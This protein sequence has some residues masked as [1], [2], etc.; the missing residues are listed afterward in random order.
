MSTSKA[1]ANAEIRCLAAARHGILTRDD[2]MGP[3]GLTESAVDRRLKN[4]DLIRLHRGIY[5][6]AAHPP[7][8]KGSVLAAQLAGGEGAFSSH[9][10]AGALYAL[11]GVPAGAVEVSVYTGRAIERVVTHRLRP[12]DRP[13]VR[14]L[15]ELRV[16]CMER[17]LLDLAGVLPK[18]AT[19][20]ALDDALRRRLTTLERMK[21]SLTEEGRAGRKGSTCLRR[22][23]AERDDDDE[24]VRTKFEAKMLWVIR[25]LP[26]PAVPNYRL[27]VEG[28]VRYLDFAFP[29]YALGIE[30]HSA[31]WH[32]AHRR[33]LRDIAR[34]RQLGR[35]G[36]FILYFA[37]DE[38]IA[39]PRAVLGEIRH[40][41]QDRGTLL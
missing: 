5:R 11:D 12:D 36:W 14:T 20:D 6:L 37:W 27:E 3:C 23:L 9:R 26:F 7:T 15:D 40:A 4:G 10:T 41:L 30:C 21:A 18:E 1:A 16:A 13:R 17:T 33:W 19:A 2:L 22:L 24:L 34:D 8:W 31:R 38:V 28:Q 39:D 35:N 32:K 25:H 29:G